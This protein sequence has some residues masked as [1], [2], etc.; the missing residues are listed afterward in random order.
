MVN[1]NIVLEFSGSAAKS[2]TRG[3]TA[4]VAINS[5][6]INIAGCLGGF[7]WGGIAELYKD[8]NVADAV[9]RKLHLLPRAVHFERRTAARGGDRIPAHLHEPEARPT[10]DAL[11]YMTSNV[12]N[13][14]FSALMQQPLRS[15]ESAMPRRK[16]DPKR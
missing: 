15:W 6:I 1:F 3:G 16:P 7:A 14:L 5:M 12:Y 10:V 13:N 4:Y 2:G 9:D 11:R 8:L